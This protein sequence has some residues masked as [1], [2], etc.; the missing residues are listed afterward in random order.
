MISPTAC[1]LIH[2]PSDAVSIRP[3]YIYRRQS[4]CEYITFF[5]LGPFSCLFKPSTSPVQSLLPALTM[6]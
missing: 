5:L 3:P 1:F 4:N 2:V 6:V